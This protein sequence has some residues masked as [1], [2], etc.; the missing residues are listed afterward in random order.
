MLAWCIS[1]LFEERNAQRFT[2]LDVGVRRGFFGTRRGGRLLIEQI[3]AS[4]PCPL[5]EVFETLAKS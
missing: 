1:H 2:H 4:Q 3:E 5:L